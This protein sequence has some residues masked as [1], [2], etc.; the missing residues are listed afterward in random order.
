MLPP[1]AQIPLAAAALTILT[2]CGQGKRVKVWT[3]QPRVHWEHVSTDPVHPVYDGYRILTPRPTHGFFPASMAVTRLAIQVEDEQG[4]TTRPYLLTDPR[5]E[6]LQWNRAFDNL[7]AIS[8]VFPIVERDLGGGEA[9][10]PQVLA[11]CRALHAK[12]GLIYAVN[13]LDRGVSEM[14]GVLYD[15]T[16]EQPMASLHALAVSVIPPGPEQ[17]DQAVDPWESDARALVRERF[18]RRVHACI[19]ELILQDARATIEA[20]KGWTPAGPIKPV[21]W[22]PRHFR[23]GRP[24]RK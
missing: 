19:R 20:P 9:D 14:F 5:N 11:A 6:F 17:G 3:P 18:E 24:W 15:T 1:G 22:P 7:M 4:Q 10:P 16:S 8:E 23:T 13:E 21:E 12:L 2:S